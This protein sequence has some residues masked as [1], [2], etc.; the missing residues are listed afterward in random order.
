MKSLLLSLVLC[1]L[2]GCAVYTPYPYADPN[3]VYQVPVVPYPPAY[4]PVYPVAYTSA[5][6]VAYAYPYYGAYWYPTVSFSASYWCCS[7]GHFR[8][9]HSHGGHGWHGGGHWRR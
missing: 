6:P 7:R 1:A 9:G 8:H 5:Y 2:P 3:V 4:T